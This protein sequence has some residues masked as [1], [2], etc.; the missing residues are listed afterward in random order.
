MALGGVRVYRVPW[1]YEEEWKT[2]LITSSLFY[3]SSLEILP[4]S[5]CLPFNSRIDST[6]DST[7]P[8]LDNNEVSSLFYRQS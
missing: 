7:S 4:I 2:A 6:L 5:P 1:W 3:V 8:S